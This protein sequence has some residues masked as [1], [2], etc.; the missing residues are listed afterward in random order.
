MPQLQL[1]NDSREAHV[2]SHDNWDYSNPRFLE[3][4]LYDQLD[5]YHFQRNYFSN[6]E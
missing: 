1:W 5:P 2:I 4:F 6:Y 3:V